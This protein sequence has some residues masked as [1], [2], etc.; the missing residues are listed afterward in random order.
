MRPIAIA[1]ALWAASSWA[2]QG[3]TL[4]AD[5]LSDAVRA[6]QDK[7]V[8]LFEIDQELTALTVRPTAGGVFLSSFRT[9]TPWFLGAAVPIGGLGI[10]FGLGGNS[11]STARTVD[12]TVGK[13]FGIGTAVLGGLLLLEL[14]VCVG[15]VIDHWVGEADGAKERAKRVAQLEAERAALR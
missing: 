7:K 10:L 14:F 1:V 5:P 15:T 13:V 3:T 2:Q 6:E 12:A 9:L 8:R 11:A 4:R